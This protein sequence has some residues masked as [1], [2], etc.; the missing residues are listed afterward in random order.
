[1]ELFSR[2]VPLVS[3]YPGLMC[4]QHIPHRR[5]QIEEYLYVQALD[6]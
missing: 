2:E 4:H 3:F 1:M 6:E 5:I